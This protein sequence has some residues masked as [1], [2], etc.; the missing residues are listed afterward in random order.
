MTTQTINGT[1]V[2]IVVILADGGT[3]PA[4]T[5]DTREAATVE[6]VDMALRA[7]ESFRTAYQ[8]ASL[9]RVESMR[10]VDEKRNGRYYLRYQYAGGM[11]EF[12]GHVTKQPKIDFKK[13]IIGVALKTDP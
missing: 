1:T 3:D 4:A 9:V 5:L 2:E 12:W 11:T 10:G 6:A 13:G 8:R 7:D